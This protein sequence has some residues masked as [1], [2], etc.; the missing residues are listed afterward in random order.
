MKIVGIIGASGKIGYSVCERLQGRCM[1]RGGSRHYSDKYDSIEAFEWKQ[2]DMKD[3]ENLYSFCQGCDIIMNCSGPAASIREK[4]AV[5]AFRAGAVYVDTSDVILSENEV[6]RKLPDGGVYVG[7][8]GYVPGLGGL[9]TK[10]ASE[11]M[12]DSLKKMNCFQGGKQ[13]FSAIAFTDIILGAIS[14]SGYPDSFFMRGAVEKERDKGSGIKEKIPGR[15]EEV[16]VKPYLSSEMFQAAKRYHIR[17]L[18]WKN[19]V[20]EESM[21][22]LIMNSFELIMTEERETAIEKITALC[23]KHI[24]EE[25]TGREWSVMIM[26]CRGKKDKAEKEMRLTYKIEKEEYACGLVGARV[27][28]SLLERTPGPGTYWPFDVVST[29]EILHMF[30]T[31]ESGEFKAE[32]RDEWKVGL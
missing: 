15:D 7:G 1:I 16:Y 5:Q 23:E 20:T 14:K 18:H 2:V 21:M 6:R 19:M 27:I 24:E 29:G 32:G 28:E 17:E 13:N 10:L 31:D 9:I 4:I 26:D 8:A 12:F 22:E 3:S 30:D 25:E 11:E